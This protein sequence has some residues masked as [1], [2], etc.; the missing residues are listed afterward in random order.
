L[1]L[2]IVHSH[3]RPG[4]VRRVI[5]LAMPYLVKALQPAATE[6]V[7]VGG[8]APDD[9]WL[10]SL[11]ERMGRVPVSLA[12]EPALGY[13]SEQQA[14]PPT[15]ARR[16]RTH[17]EQ[18]LAG[19]S[20]KNA[21]VWAHNQ[22]LGRNLLLA[23][24]LEEI[25]GATGVPLVFH[26]HDWWFDNR[27]SRWPEMQEAGY[28]TLAEVA[29]A[30]LP[31]A[32]N[33]RH[34]TIN[35]ADAAVLER[36]LGERVGWIPNLTEPAV[37]PTAP[38]MRRA[39]SWLRERLG[40]DAPVWLLPCRLLRRK[41][42]AEALL[43]T[44]WLRPGGWLV[45]T[46]DVS[47][48]DE[49]AYADA[50]Q[51]A[52]LQ[53]GWRLRLSVLAG[54]ETQKPTVPELLAASEAVLLTSLQEGFGL[55]NLEAAAAGRPLITRTLENV[56]PDLA[57]FGFDFPQTYQDVAIDPALFDWKAERQR[58]AQRF[59]EWRS[60]LPQACR[61][62]VEEPPVLEST[63][64]PKSVAFSRLTLPAQLEVL[65]V[66]AATSW[67]TCVSLNPFLERWRERA[68]DGELAI[69]HWPS[70]AAK[71]LSGAAYGARFVELLQRKP[72][73]AVPS[74]AAERAVDDFIRAKLA[75]E[76]QYP[77]L[78]SSEP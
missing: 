52:A 41:N 49:Q 40:D 60:R 28:K 27:W 73:K 62:L 70:S 64:P 15:L 11:Q 25:C 43:L 46:G 78:W 76:N 33:V 26:H 51:A 47:S 21:V 59:R 35:Q 72:S 29:R 71:W 74:E 8:E 67:E 66:P 75:A 14:G 38:R 36:T 39:K 37:P 44:R 12:I 54:D 77:L 53:H 5:E 24:S 61:A 34:A 48:A 19:L 10:G 58:Q 1:K 4:G 18:C 69:P 42:V 13:F 55:P 50:L 9:G 63:K 2:L 16:I 45:T 65:F 32:S 3:Y 68:T 57:R 30:I 7:L 56:A 20:A 17:L 23:Q 22:G 6:I 31:T